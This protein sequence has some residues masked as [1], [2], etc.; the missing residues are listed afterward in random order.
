MDFKD[1]FFII[2]K[3]RYRSSTRGREVANGLIGVQKT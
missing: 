1:V 3:H 2:I